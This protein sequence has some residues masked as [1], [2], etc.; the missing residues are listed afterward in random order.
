M[1]KILITGA[2]GF[3]GSAL[4]RHFFQLGED[5]IL[6]VRNKEK[7]PVEWLESSRVAVVEGDI[8]DEAS[9]RRAV[10][11]AD[12]IVHGAVH[13]DNFS[14][15]QARR[16][17]VEGTRN[18]L[19][20]ARGHRVKNVVALSTCAVY[21]LRTVGEVDERSP[22]I[23]S[24]DVY[25][26]TK[27]EAEKV[28]LEHARSLPVTIL[29]IPSVYGQGSKLWTKDL[30]DMLLER[31]FPLINGGSGAFAC[32]YI[33]DLVC[34]VS[35]VLQE[36][37]A[38]GEVFNVIG[39]QTTLGTF[40]TRYCDA[41]GAPMPRSIPGWAAKAYACAHLAVAKAVGRPPAIHPKTIDMLTIQV[42]YN[43][44]KLRSFGWKPV[45]GLGEGLI[46]SAE[47]YRSRNASLN[48]PEYRVAGRLRDAREHMT[49]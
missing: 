21:G 31:K 15:E 44:D 6:F 29:R 23:P 28:C 7:L 33:D 40:V 25:C 27:I 46:R 49:D 12:R 32:V 26:D 41:L 39:E 22:L 36:P 19:N 30:G 8:T 4:A 14:R 1:G 38:Y 17:N 18:L 2:A 34:A 11:G 10:S 16:V 3:I 43:G 20:A 9:V 35:L 45:T 37:G 42:R 5:L 48:I 47:W 24:N 13:P